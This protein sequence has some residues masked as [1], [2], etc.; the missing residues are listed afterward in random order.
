M[1]AEPQAA[2]C[3]ELDRLAGT[4]PVLG[5]AVSGGGDS[6]ALLNIAAD[7]ARA[8]G[9]MLCAATV[10]HAL[11]PGSA[12]EA[13]AVAEGCAALGV[14]HQVLRWDHGGILSGNLMA[15]ARAARMRLLADWAVAQGAA[16]VALGHTQ[17]DQAETLLMRL[18]RGAGVDGLSGMSPLREQGGMR[19]LRPMLGVRRAAL[20]DWLRLR[21]IAWADDPTNDDPAYDRVR[22]RQAIAALNLPVAQIAR[23]AAMLAEARAALAETAALAARG[24]VADRGMLSLP[25]AALDQPAEIVRRLV[26][27]AIRWVSGADYAPRGEDLARLIAALSA[28]GQATLAGVIARRRGGV[29]EVMREVAAVPRGAAAGPG[30]CPGPQDISGRKTVI[31]DNRWQI[32]GLPEGA[33]VRA[34]DGGDLAG[35]DWRAAGLPRLALLSSPAVEAGDG[36]VVVP[37]LEPGAGIALRPLRDTADYIALLRAH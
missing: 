13:D 22:V 33:V 30:L 12:A 20:R 4:L 25:G 3:Q 2:I 15:E 37:L 9:I 27:A 36:G 24:A 5:V 21:G 17:D 8:R 28:G 18:A 32:A 23:S 10:D 26:A 16:A 31:W 29:V 7:W 14:P 35:R 19:W 34:L 1:A 11:R 6:V